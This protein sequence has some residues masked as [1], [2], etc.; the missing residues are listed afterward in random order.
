MACEPSLGM[1]ELLF[2]QP[3]FAVIQSVLHVLAAIVEPLAK[4][5]A[6]PMHTVSLSVSAY[7]NH[8]LSA[9]RSCS[10]VSGLYQVSSNT[11]D[12]AHKQ[13][14]RHHTQCCPTLVHEGIR[15]CLAKKVLAIY[16]PSWSV[17][18]S[19]YC[20]IAQVTIQL[21]GCHDS[22]TCPQIRGKRLAA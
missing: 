2:L 3:V 11:S 14:V 12:L 9:L 13:C 7:I 1:T 15:T 21:H 5:L 22:E 8:V 10:I 19:C 17:V 16:G 20:T 4:P 6:L 18:H